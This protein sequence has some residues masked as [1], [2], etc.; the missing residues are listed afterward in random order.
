MILFSASTTFRF[1][2]VSRENIS[3]FRSFSLFSFFQISRHSSWCAFR[4]ARRNL[5]RDQSSHISCDI[6]TLAVEQA[7]DK[8]NDSSWITESKVSRWRRDK[9]AE[10]EAVLLIF[11]E[12]LS[13]LF[14]GFTADSFVTNR[15]YEQSHRPRL[16]A[17]IQWE[18]S[19]RS[20]SSGVFFYQLL[21]NSFSC[22]Q[23]ISYQ[24]FFITNHR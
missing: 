10:S 19:C 15:F 3:S 8:A 20:R 14:V 18:S 4:N 2:L 9:A 12:N 16:F 7:V 13:S 21:R 23:R 5:G 11:Q 22:S 6:A 24:E 1:F 17:S